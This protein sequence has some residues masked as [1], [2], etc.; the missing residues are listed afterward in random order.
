[1]VN[2]FCN[3]CCLRSCS[4]LFLK[5]NQNIDVVDYYFYKFVNSKTNA[6]FATNS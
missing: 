2:T 3:S 1:M 4:P 6:N 5:H